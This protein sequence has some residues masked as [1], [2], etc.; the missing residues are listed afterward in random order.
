MRPDTVHDAEEALSGLTVSRETMDRLA[1]YVALL[2]RW[3]SIHN[4]VAP[5]TLDEVWSRHIADSA[6]LVAL[7]PAAAR[8][9]D[10]GS[11]AGL[12][13]LVVAILIQGRPGAWV[14]LVE[15]NHKKC[16]FLREAIRATGAPAEVYCARIESVVKQWTKPVDVIT[17]RAL[18][19]LPALCGFVA[20]LVAHGAV[21]VFHKGRNF[22]AELRE[23][24]QTW[25][26]D[27]VQ[28][29]SREG[30]GRIVEVRRL[31]RREKGT[32]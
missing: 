27:L 1:A 31:S 22:E 23:A 8:W 13:G 7:F 12:P 20:P 30:D 15:A 29:P 3:Q 2:R 21:A 18:A 32:P 25:D 14:G 17:A 9:L 5:A 26:I 24:S 16:A 11:G 4:L 10:L 28:H 19:P 6:Q